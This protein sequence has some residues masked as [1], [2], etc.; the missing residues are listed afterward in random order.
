MISSKFFGGHDDDGWMVIQ[1]RLYTLLMRDCWGIDKLGIYS[2]VKFPSFQELSK[3]STRSQDVI[4]E[5][6]YFRVFWHQPRP[7]KMSGREAK[8]LLY[9]PEY[10]WT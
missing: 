4:N 2:L 5:D 1:N 6:D 3:L 10:K 7:T 8:S 9:P